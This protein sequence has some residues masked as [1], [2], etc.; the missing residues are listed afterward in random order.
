MKMTRKEIEKIFFEAVEILRKLAPKDTGNL[1]YNAIKFKWVSDTHFKIYV[2][3]GNGE[4]KSIGVAP[5]MPFTNEI[6]LSPKWKGKKNPNEGWWDRAV[7][8]ITI[9]IAK[10]L[11]GELKV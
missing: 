2:D 10:R 6:W 8:V 9:Y 1:A 4:S 5:Y 7:K 11:N 3:M